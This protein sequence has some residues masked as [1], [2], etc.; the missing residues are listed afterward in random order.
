MRKECDLTEGADKLEHIPDLKLLFAEWM[1]ASP[2]KKASVRT[3]KHSIPNENTLMRCQ[4]FDKF[5]QS[6]G[7]CDRPFGAK[8][9]NSMVDSGK[10]P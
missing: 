10:N 3:G 8:S 1:R 4:L 7:G 6:V 2:M 5:K 9:E